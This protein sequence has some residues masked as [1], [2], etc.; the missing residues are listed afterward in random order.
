MMQNIPGQ[1]KTDPEKIKRDIRRKPAVVVQP[2]TYKKLQRGVATIVEAVKPTLG[3]LP[4]LVVLERLNRA[5]VP[6]FLD[7]G[8]TIAR[9]VI[10]IQPRSSDVGAMMVRRALW[11]MHLTVG[12]GT[13]TMAV[14][15]QVLVQE[16]IRYITRFGYNPMLL[17]TSLHKGLRLV[18][19]ALSQAVLPVTGKEQ[20]AQ[21][22]LGMCQDNQELADILGEIFDIISPEG[23]IFV[24]GWN[25]RGIDREY[26]EG[27]YWKFSGWFSRYF[28]TEMDGDKA[29]F[30]DAALLL[31]DMELK[32]PNEVI[33]ILEKCVQARIKR[34]VILAKEVSDSV[35]GLLLNNNRAKSIESIAVRAPGIIEL[36]RVGILEDLAVQTGGKVFYAASKFG[37]SDFKVEDL[38]NARR[39]WATDSLF[40]YYGGKG[41]PRQVRQQVMKLRNMLKATD[42][43]REHEKLQGRLGRMVG[44]TAILRLGAVHETER[45]AIKTLTERAINGLRAVIQ[46]GVVPG[47]GAALMNC[48][49]ALAHP[50]GFPDEEAV[51]FRILSRALEEPLRVISHN[52]GRQ[53]D[54]IAEKVKDC[55]QGFG[56]EARSGQFVDMVQAGI[57]DSYLVI[58][59]AVEVAV[60]SA[61]MLLT[62]DVI[63]HSSEPVESVE[64]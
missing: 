60:S 15:Y 64:P 22:A 33:P 12:D 5:E 29:T 16:G 62:T 13:T 34:L 55:P 43:K 47:G 4:R 38:G 36:D 63:V 51:A 28:V 3:P 37:L 35:I 61:A 59:K 18:K 39:V 48:Q 24:E 56:Y 44:G 27:T 7:D 6:E 10:Q 30:E 52:A 32:D 20:I 54:I 50:A 57:L 17:R 31:T 2:E 41:D 46:G 23:M 19:E 9:R 25:K 49:Q 1:S 45:E 11:D 58:E 26:I 14:M 8:A 40:G 42:D 53:P 21:I